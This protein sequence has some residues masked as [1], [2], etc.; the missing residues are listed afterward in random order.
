MIIIISTCI[1]LYTK[2]M[3]KKASHRDKYTFEYIYIYIQMCNMC[4]YSHT[5]TYMLSICVTFLYIAFVNT[6]VNFKYIIVI[7]KFVYLHI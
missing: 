3:Y 7:D 6:E 5:H 1:I 4:K 2:A